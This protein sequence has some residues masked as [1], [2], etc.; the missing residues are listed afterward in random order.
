MGPESNQ[1]LAIR[2]GIDVGADTDLMSEAWWSPG[3]THPDGS[4]TFSLWFT[5]G[6]FVD[7]NG[8]RFVNESWAYDRIGRVVIDRMAEGTRHVAL[9]DGLRRP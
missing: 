2:A 4:S 3:V 6:I 9:L 8:E 5:G 7:D 1:G